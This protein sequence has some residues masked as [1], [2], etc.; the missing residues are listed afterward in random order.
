MPVRLYYSPVRHSYALFYHPTIGVVRQKKILFRDNQYSIIPQ[1][2][3]SIESPQRSIKVRIELHQ[4]LLR[5]K[6]SFYLIENFFR[7]RRD[8]RKIKRDEIEN[9]ETINTENNQTQEETDIWKTVVER[10]DRLNSNQQP[11]RRRTFM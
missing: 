10:N 3:D 9:D 5:M 8:I 7:S 1:K 4:G 11:P 6:N 2:L